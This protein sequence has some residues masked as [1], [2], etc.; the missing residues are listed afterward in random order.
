MPTIKNMSLADFERGGET[1][2]YAIRITNDR[3]L[4][5]FTPRNYSKLLI[6]DINDVNNSGS[7]FSSQRNLLSIIDFLSVA[8]EKNKD[9]V[10]HCDNSLNYSAAVASFAIQSLGFTN[11]E[12]LD[13]RAI[14]ND[15]IVALK[16]TF[17]D[18]NKEKSNE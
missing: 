4:L 10:V 15:I 12:H 8:K 14:D 13:C 5:R 16:T 1:A 17:N 2:P 3:N 18:L 6:L 7:R 9:V 11:T